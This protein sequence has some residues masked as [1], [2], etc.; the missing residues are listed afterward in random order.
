MWTVEERRWRKGFRRLSSNESL[1]RYRFDDLGWRGR[2]PNE[3]TRVIPRFIAF[4]LQRDVCKLDFYEVSK[5]PILNKTSFSSWQAKLQNL[6]TCIC[7]RKVLCVGK[8]AE[9]VFFFGRG[10]A[11]ARALLENGFSKRR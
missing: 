10:Q 5:G 11:R 6:P 4:R 3:A 2:R 7:T 8:V 1:L 9:T